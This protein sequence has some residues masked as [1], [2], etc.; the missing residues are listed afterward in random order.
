MLPGPWTAT[1][2]AE[3]LREANQLFDPNLSA[4]QFEAALHRSGYTLVAE[5]D[6]YAIAPQIPE[7]SATAA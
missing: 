5:G 2:L 4:Q 3:A 7:I 1:S 6:V